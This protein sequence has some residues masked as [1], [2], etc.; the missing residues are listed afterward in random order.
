M[1]SRERPVTLRFWTAREYIAYLQ[2]FAETFG[3][4]NHIRFGHRVTKIERLTDGS[5]KWSLAFKSGEKFSYKGLPTP[6]AVEAAT[7][8]LKCDLLVCCTGTHGKPH[9]PDLPG[10]K[11][12]CGE[13]THSS[14]YVNA[15]PFKGKHVLIVGAGESGSDIV[16]EVAEVAGWARRDQSVRF[17]SCTDRS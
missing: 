8:E 17:D 6:P 5:A 7:G 14:T 12:F 9:I 15:A 1:F 3:L 10:L 11:T 4:L 16:R 13:T 2:E